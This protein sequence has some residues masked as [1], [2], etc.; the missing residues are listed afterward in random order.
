MS[1]QEGNLK[2]IA[3]AIR[4]KEGTTEPIPANSFA[5]RILALE[6]GGAPEGVCT[7]NLTASD[8]DGGTVEGGGV[9]S[10]DMTITVDAKVNAKGN[11]YFDGWE[12][13]GE[14]VSEDPQ[15]TFPVTADRNLTALFLE[16]QYVAGVDWWECK[17]PAYA[18]WTAVTYGNGKFVTIAFNRDMAAYST[19][20]IN[21]TN[22]TLPVSASWNGLTYGNG[23]F[24]AVAGNSTTV[25]YSTDGINWVTAKL[26]VY[27]NWGHITYGDGKFVAIDFISDI[28]AY[29]AD[30]INWER[31]TLPV[32]ANW[33]HI[34][35]GTGKFV[36]VAHNNDIA[37]YSADGINWEKTTLPFSAAW[38]C[39]TYGNGIF[40]SVSLNSD[41]AAYSSA[42]GPGV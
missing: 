1:T 26:P 5:S 30:G 42:K 16:T 27:A 9:A 15:Y 20:G 40:V 8:P 7:I 3:D 6:A 21:W 19:D 25:V 12:E 29:S 14:V 17:L 37:A 31:T 18:G 4:Q 39:V 32:S 35:Y 11:F 28:A 2:A 36:A 22:A 23:K 10:K 24:V 34:T 13:N 41:K 38:K 33:S